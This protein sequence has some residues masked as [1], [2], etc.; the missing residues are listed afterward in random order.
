MAAPHIRPTVIPD[1]FTVFAA[2]DIHGQLGAVDRLLARAGLSDGADR[3]VAPAG[4]ALVVTGDVVDRGPDSLG[5]VRR[6]ASLRAQAPARGGIVAILEGNHEIQVLGGLGGQPEIFGAL[7]AFGGGATLRSAG[8]RPDEWEGRSSAEISARVGDLAPDLVP[9]LW[10]FAP[11]ARW[12]DVL[13]VH[14]GPVPFEDLDRFERSADRL[15]IRDA[16]YASTERF[17][18][19]ACWAPYREAGIRRVV[20]GHTPVERPTLSHDGNALNLDTW[21]GHHVTLARLEPGVELRDASFLVEPAEPRAIA[22]APVPPEE[23]RRLDATLPAIVDAW[24]AGLTAR[25]PGP[26]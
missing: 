18:E 21:R 3:W 4:T 14:G 26:R 11:Y 6:L 8:L 1:S 19:A 2:S 22:D 5:L 23:V 10:T 7:M 17:P 20:F 12:G 16:F 25:A 24:I 15:W 13:L 9:T